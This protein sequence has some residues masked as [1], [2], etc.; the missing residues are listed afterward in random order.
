MLQFLLYTTISQQNTDELVK[1]WPNI[2]HDLVANIRSLSEKLL[3]IQELVTVVVK[4][5]K[6]SHGWL[7]VETILA[8]VK[9][10]S[11]AIF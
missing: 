9:I 7:N 1:S 6:F 5:V 4:I 8:L 2:T 10:K 11:Q 3:K